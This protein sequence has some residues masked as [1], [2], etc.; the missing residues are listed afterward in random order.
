V[1]H[2]GHE[3][4]FFYNKKLRRIAG[5]PEKQV[6]PTD[7]GR[8]ACMLPQGNQKAVEIKKSLISG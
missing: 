2:E 3:G 6:R 8:P 4:Q 7:R 1:G 5:D